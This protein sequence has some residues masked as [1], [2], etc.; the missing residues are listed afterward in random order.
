MDKQAIHDKIAEVI[1]ELFDI[2]RSR[3]TLDA[4]FEDL[5]LTSID[6]IDMVVELQRF[7]GKKLTESGLRS[8]RT[9][10]DVVE[11]VHAHVTSSERTF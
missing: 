10:G 5:E 3:I 6:A 11:L 2:D 9:V 8:V 4:K 7:T 1:S